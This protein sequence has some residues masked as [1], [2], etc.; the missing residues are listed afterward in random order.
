LTA[1]HTPFAETGRSSHPPV[2][3]IRISMSYLALAKKGPAKLFAKIRKILLTV[4]T[5]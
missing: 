3:L 2:E 5:T 4:T 1:T